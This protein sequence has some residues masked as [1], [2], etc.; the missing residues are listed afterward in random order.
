MWFEL[1]V[2]RIVVIFIHH[3]YCYRNLFNGGSQRLEYW[4]VVVFL[5][6]LSISTIPM[7]LAIFYMFIYIKQKL[8]NLK[9]Q[10][11]VFVIY[12]IYPFFIDL[13]RLIGLKVE[14]YHPPIYHAITKC[15]NSLFIIF[16]NIDGNKIRKNKEIHWY[17]DGDESKR[18][19]N[20]RYKEVI[21]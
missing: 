19:D 5:F 20:L 21:C 17:L 12:L 18:L 9:Y 11:A 14:Y 13:F 4:K 2:F 6:Y 16:S 3:H 8:F 1:F 7:P 15:R 10:N